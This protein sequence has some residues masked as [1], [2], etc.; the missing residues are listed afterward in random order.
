MTKEPISIPAGSDTNVSELKTRLYAAEY[1]EN[2]VIMGIRGNIPSDTKLTIKNIKDSFYLQNI[3]AETI[4]SFTG[5]TSTSLGMVSEKDRELLAHKIKDAVYKDKLNIVSKEFKEKNAMILLFDPLIKTHFH[6]LTIDAKIGDKATSLRG[7]TQV[8]FDFFYLKWE[9]VVKAFSQYVRER[10]SDSIQLIS[11]DPTTFNFMQEFKRI[12][13]QKVFVVPTKVSILQGYDFQ[14]DIKGIL[15]T[16]KSSIVGKSIEEARKLILSYPEIA[17][18]KINL[19]LLGGT[20]LPS[21][22][23]RIDVEVDF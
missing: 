4:E 7:N 12:I 18:T 16:I 23:S 9:D 5:G 22:K 14:R 15:T 13:D 17:S 6:T 20:T 11:I 19:G 2:G 3:W 1:D 10:Q 21:I 8:S